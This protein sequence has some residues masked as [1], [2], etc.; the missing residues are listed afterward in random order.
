MNSENWNTIPILSAAI[1]SYAEAKTGYDSAAQEHDSQCNRPVSEAKEARSGTFYEKKIENKSIKSSPPLASL[2]TVATNANN[3]AGIH[4]AANPGSSRDIAAKP[5]TGRPANASL[6]KV[7]RLVNDLGAD[8]F[9]TPSGVPHAMVHDGQRCQTLR[10]GSQA[11]ARWLLTMCVEHKLG[12][13]SRSVLEQATSILEGVAEQAVRET[14]VRLGHADDH[15]YLDLGDDS[16]QVVDISDDDWQVVDNPGLPF[17]RP[18]S[19]LSLPMPVRGGN[20]RQLQTVLNAQ[21]DAEFI[22]LASWLVGTLNPH[23]PYPPLGV[24]GEPGS[25][26]TTTTRVLCNVIDPS[27]VVGR[28]LPRSEQELLIGAC[29]GHIYSLD[30]VSRLQPWLSDAFCR[31]ATGSAFT[32]RSLYTNFDEILLSAIKPVVL[33]G[34]PDVLERDDLRDRA[35]IV[36][37]PPIAADRRTSEQDV[38]KAFREMHPQVLGALLDT[39]VMALRNLGRTSLSGLPRMADFALWVA[40]AEPALPWRP[41]EFMSTYVGNIADAVANSLDGNA[42]ADVLRAFCRERGPQWS[43]SVSELY[44]LLL[45]TYVSE[46]QQESGDWPANARWLSTRLMEIAPALRTSGIDVR[47]NAGRDRGVRINAVN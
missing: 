43:G 28:S 10:V 37:L 29:N 11:F 21:S 16:G 2:A 1:A 17:V 5:V 25:A 46:D 42:V 23:G 12:I 22:P 34:I 44:K 18:Q 33:N 41:G 32:A 45:T 4:A 3:D 13:E 20:L 27:T 14:F 35:I 31:I 7:I 15:L 8:L 26:K 39:A 9:R 19:M 47:V 38:W 24:R 36:N 30:N 6:L 40:A